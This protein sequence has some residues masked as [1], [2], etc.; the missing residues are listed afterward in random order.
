[1]ACLS[2]W[3]FGGV[4]AGASL[5]LD[6]GVVLVAVLGMVSARGV[7]RVRNL[8]CAPSLAL[9]GLV[10][11]AAVQ[12]APLPGGIFQRVAPSSASLHAALAPEAPARVLGDPGPAVG[13]PA[14][15][16]SQHPEMTVD[17][18]ARLAAAW[19]LL[20]A[21][22]ALRGG[23]GAL[24]RFGTAMAVN[25]ALLALFAVIQALS[26]NGRIYWV[27]ESASTG[28]GGPFVNKNHLAAYLNLGLGFALGVLLSP[29]PPGSRR[30]A[31]PRRLA[32]AYAAGLIVV[33]VLN[34]LSRGGVVAMLAASAVTFGVLAR[35]RTLRVGV[36]VAAMLGLTAL[37]L[38]G[39][40]AL[41]PYR[42]VATLLDAAA[43]A[44]RL[45]GW[46]GAMRAWSIYPVW[47]IGLG[48]FAVAMLRF[49]AD[50]GGRFLSHAENEYI[51]ILVEGGVVG[52]ALVL[53][54]LA[55]V[56]A[57]GRRA[58]GA[59]PD[60]RRRAPI[61][62]AL[63][64][65]VSL[66]VHCLADFPMH[67]PAVAVPAVVLSGHL[68]RLGL[69]ARRPGTSATPGRRIGSA[70]VGAVMVAASLLALWHGLRMA[71][72]EAALAGGG[73]PPPGS[74]VSGVYEQL[75]AVLW[76]APAPAL[77]R[78]R[79]HLERA[80]RHRPDWA[81]GHARLGLVRLSQYAA[82]VA[83]QL[84]EVGDPARVAVLSDPLSLH[85]AVHA[86]TAEQL[87]AAGGVLGP[88]PVR[89]YLVPAARSFLEARRCCPVWA[90]P[91][92]E[93]ATLDYLLVG[94]E[95]TSAH[96][97]RAL[98]MADSDAPTILRAAGASAQA[99]DL[100]LA[101][102]C[103]RRA[104]EIRPEGWR[105]VAEVAGALLPPDQV[106][107]RVVPSGHL[108]VLF[109]EALFAAPDRRAERDRFLRA[110]V[111]RLPRDDDPPKAERLQIEGRAWALL[112]D[113][114]RAR[115]R[116]EAALALEPNRSAWRRELVEWLVAWGRPRDAHDQALIGISLSP[117][118]PDAV[119]ALD[120]AAEALARGD[121]QPPEQGRDDPPKLKP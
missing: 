5:A 83:E 3:A 117:G 50:L 111:E 82:A 120:L 53:V 14:P 36:G 91:H 11:L 118:D 97:L 47:G 106:L 78:S 98:R 56:V 57:L 29:A 18:A 13:P 19:V 100:A 27:R 25:A 35:P 51:Q 108:A 7:D 45:E 30:W 110:A 114:D 70:L 44:E 95:A 85:K 34:S 2:P 88:E 76:G 119:K 104:L 61:L 73:V 93:L 113:N 33:G 10:V 39:V 32:A 80:L 96:A 58:L 4:E 90:L 23:D 63:F 71:R 105:E 99:G 60:P 121:S 54:I 103:W 28:H 42:R 48:S 37:F 102:R 24:R 43:Y 16:I 62:G 59:D 79:E 116:M 84:G 69:D 52:L 115:D 41:V 74:A 77:E 94:G 72:A 81:E 8:S 6:A 92:A 55:S 46:A 64:G 112:G 31:D 20:Q 89:L 87:A 67:I 17:A 1:M 9:A 101:A 12:V 68:A 15:T 22:L 49:Y 65:V 75:S 107:D 66:A 109:A 38:A 21:V 40:G 86:A 26:W